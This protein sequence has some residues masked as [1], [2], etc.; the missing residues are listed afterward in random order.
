MNYELVRQDSPEI[1]ALTGNRGWT[2]SDS[3]LRKTFL[4]DNFTRALSF[5]TAVA[6]ESEKRNHH[7]EW[8]NVYSRVEIHWTTHDV[9]GLSTLDVE[10]ANLCDILSKQQQ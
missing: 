4:F 1:T 6:I 10:L 5:M 2:L 7:P 8:T 3:K 9:S